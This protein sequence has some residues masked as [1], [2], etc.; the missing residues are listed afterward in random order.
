MNRCPSASVCVCVGGV[1]STPPLYTRSSDLQTDDVHT[2]TQSTGMGVQRSL[3]TETV[4]QE[5]RHDERNT[6]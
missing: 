3:A 2:H 1:E 5:A 4:P 6:T